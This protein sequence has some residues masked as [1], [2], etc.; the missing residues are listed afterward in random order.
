MT[1]HHLPKLG[2]KRAIVLF[3]LV[4]A[5]L[6]GYFSYSYIRVDMRNTQY[7]DKLQAVV[8]LAGTDNRPLKDVRTAALREAANLRLPI[9]TENIRIT[10]SGQSLNV[11]VDYEVG[12]DIPL[13]RRHLYRHYTH[14]VRFRQIR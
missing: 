14:N 6:Y 1:E 12:I 9:D 4:V 10:G 11:V 13:I 2:V 7:Q 8:Q 3:W 5:I